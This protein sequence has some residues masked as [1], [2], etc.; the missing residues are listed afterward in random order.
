MWEKGFDKWKMKYL[1]PSETESSN[2]SAI[3]EDLKVN[4]RPEPDFGHLD[5]LK[6]MQMQKPT[7]TNQL[8]L[9]A[10]R[11]DMLK[12]K[13]QP[14]AAVLENDKSNVPFDLNQD[15]EDHFYGRK[16]KEQKQD[17][18]QNKEKLNRE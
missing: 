14:P 3:P 6:R 1:N 4:D 10:A 9:K 16:S 13:I 11:T 5:S 8:I 18:E 17:Q 15:L 2:H 12:A 7:L